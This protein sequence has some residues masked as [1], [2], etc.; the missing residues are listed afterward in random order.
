V[1]V[2]WILFGSA[3]L[4]EKPAA[5]QL[6]SFDRCRPLL[7]KQMKCVGNTYWLHPTETFKPH[8]V[9]ACF[10]QCVSVQN[11]YF[12]LHN[13][14]A[15]NYFADC[16]TKAVYWTCR[17]GAPAVLGNGLPLQLY[18]FEHRHSRRFSPRI[19]Y[20]G[21]LKSNAEFHSLLRG[22][23]ALVIFHYVTRSA[24][25][26]IRRK[27]FSGTK[28]FVATGFQASATPGANVTSE[29]RQRFHEYEAQLELTSDQPICRQG[30]K[31]AAGF[32]F[33]AFD[34]PILESDEVV[35]SSDARLRI[36]SWSQYA[37]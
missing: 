1:S 11:A 8:D 10:L 2:Q 22:E 7:T 9:H 28:G 29:L 13:S 6:A 14:C 20:D 12:F 5:G 26:F 21:H 17:P 33:N 36:M 27:V 25:E 19:S 15:R 16:K 34:T 18:R 23:Q 31:L 3:G 4:N 35:S 30:S 32:K 24:D 37:T